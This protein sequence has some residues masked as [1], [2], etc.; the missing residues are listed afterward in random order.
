MKVGQLSC[1][2]IAISILATSVFAQ[3]PKP[4]E[5]SSAATDLPRV[6]HPD[7]SAKLKITLRIYDFAKIDPAVL[8]AA[9]EVTTEILRAAG[10]EADWID[11]SATQINC[12]EEGNRPH[13]RL[14][15]LSGAL[16][17]DIV[18]DEALGFAV[19]CARNEQFCLS[20]IFYSRIS[21]LAAAHGPGPDRILGHVMAH[22]VG[23]A[24]LGPSSHALFG[25]MQSQLRVYDMERILYF[26]SAQSKHMR[27]ELCTRNQPQ[28]K[29]GE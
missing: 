27:S 5:M 8:I 9:R 2:A 23:H 20:Y 11:C 18:K 4:F 15:I 10:L 22:E 16:V 17:R 3:L 6:H 13:F 26:T 14:R 1:V 28:D 25:I 19:P 29:V 12:D 21:A 24:L 7:R